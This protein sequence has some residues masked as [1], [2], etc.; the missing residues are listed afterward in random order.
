[1]FTFFYTWVL[2][3]IDPLLWLSNQLSSYSYLQRCNSLSPTPLK[4]LLFK[5]DQNFSLEFLCGRLSC[6]REFKSNF[7]QHSF[8]ANFQK[9]FG[10]S[11]KRCLMHSYRKS[12]ITLISYFTFQENEFWIDKMVWNFLRIKHV[13]FFYDHKRCIRTIFFWKMLTLF[14]SLVLGLL[15]C[16][17][18]LLW[19]RWWCIIYVLRT[20]LTT[21][22][23]LGIFFSFFSWK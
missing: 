6:I 10:K 4:N 22:L 11:P 7:Q 23:F 15:W 18:L 3:Q 20:M 17:F 9:P 19:L 5:C 14:L 16:W 12:I 21:F 1:M 8:G 2:L 13:V